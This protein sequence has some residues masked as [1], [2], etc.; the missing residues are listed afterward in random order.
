MNKK[1]IVQIFLIIILILITFL[2]FNLYYVDNSKQVK[3]NS[4]M[5]ID[6][7]DKSNDNDNNLIKDI[8]YSSN[9]NKG[10][11]YEIL[12]DYGEP[13]LIDP[14]LMFL[15]NVTAT[16]IFVDKAD[17]RLKSKF[18]NFNTKTFETTFI[19]DVKIVRSDE[20]ITGDELYLVLDSD[21][22]LLKKNPNIEQNLIRI[23][24]NILY[25]KPGYILKADVIEID[26]ITK[27]SKIYMNDKLKKV[28][29]QSKIK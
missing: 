13:S 8:K 18:A 4:T 14:N 7:L 10:D 21:P 11:I 22:E 17:V 6:D 26:L 27:N 19:N 20:I 23:S 5:N 29:A 1:T 2:F 15:T 12:A 25:E 24:R 16:I 3:T 28:L 9:N